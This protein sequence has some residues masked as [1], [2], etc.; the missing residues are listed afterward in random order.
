MTA[1]LLIPLYIEPDPNS[2]IELYYTKPM[3]FLLSN[4]LRIYLFNLVTSYVYFTVLCFSEPPVRQHLK[5]VYGTLAISTVAAAGGASVHLYTD[6]LRA[7]FF[8]SIG[9]IVTFFLLLMTPDNGKNTMQR[10][11]YLLAFAALTG[12]GLGPVLEMI[13]MI[14]PSIIVTAIFGTAVVFTSFTLCALFA[15]DG[16]FLF[17]AAPLVNIMTYMMIAGLLNIF[18]GSQIIYNVQML[19]GLGIMVCFVL[20]DT[21]AIIEKRRLGNKDFVSHSL[22]LFVDLIGIFRRIIQI[23]L[24]KEEMDRRRRN[25]D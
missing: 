12:L 21:Q 6:Y 15:T 14:N 10:L 9:A 1:H 11:S 13:I 3:I 24:Q 8:T 20:Y 22:D 4:R 23:L 25:R 7:S 2:V 5:N 18:I 16:K 19:V 17:L